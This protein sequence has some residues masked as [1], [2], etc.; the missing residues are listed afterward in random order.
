MTTV[1]VAPVS[2]HVF[3]GSSCGMMVAVLLSEER[4]A[5]NEAVF[6]DANEEIRA[7]RTELEMTDGKTPF[8][9]ECEDTACRELMR[10]DLAEYEAVRAHPERFVIA[11][12]H[13]SSGAPVAEHE[14]YVV[15]E[16]DG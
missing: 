13:P 12:G 9:C 2:D 14:T 5:Q 1:E 15:V 6:R 7:V 11:V 10:L 4:K 3:R 8:F 16:K